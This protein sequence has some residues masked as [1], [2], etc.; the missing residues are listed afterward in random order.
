MKLQASHLYKSFGA[1]DVL[2][3]ASLTVKGNEK[4]ALVGRNGCGKTTLLKMICHLE[5]PDQGS[6]VIA[7]GTRIGYLSQ[8]TFED[9]ERTVYEELL[10]VF[11]ELTT[12]QAR[13]ESQALVLEH[14]ASSAQL[15][16]Y[17]KL[18]NRFEALG[19]YD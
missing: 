15:E 2:S 17:E 10:A 1:Q 5:E 6:V 9:E 13:L 18:Q 19:G 12:L 4:I 14:D 3:D 7:S 11:D 16:K 8:I